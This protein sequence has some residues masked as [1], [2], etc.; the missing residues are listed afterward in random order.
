M[1]F[2]G[3]LQ[4]FNKSKAFKKSTST[5][6]EVLAE[7]CLVQWF[8]SIQDNAQHI[9]KMFTGIDSV[10]ICFKPNYSLINGGHCKNIE[11]TQI[12]RRWKMPN[13]VNANTLNFLRGKRTGAGAFICCYLHHFLYP[14]PEYFRKK[15]LTHLHCYTRKWKLEPE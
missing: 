1:C 13:Q 10:L 6:M 5:R 15:M 11:Q 3:S 14:L 9:R 8:S 12:F 2:F 4:I 7:I